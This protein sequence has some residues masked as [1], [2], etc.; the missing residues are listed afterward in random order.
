MKNKINTIIKSTPLLILFCLLISCSQ[1]DY[2]DSDQHETKGNYIE[3]SFN[4]NKNE[5]ITS[6][7]ESTNDIEELYALEFDAKGVFISTQ[8]VDELAES[9]FK[10]MLKPTSEQRIIHFVGGH[11]SVLSS[12]DLLNEVKLKG[13]DE[14]EILPKFTTQ[15]L[16]Y[17]DR[18][19]LKNGIAN[20]TP[21]HTVSL[22]RNKAKL[23]VENQTSTDLFKLHSFAVHKAADSGTI[24]SF[25]SNTDVFDTSNATEP[26]T[27]KYLD[28]TDESFVASQE[29]LSLFERRAAF[30]GSDGSGDLYIILKGEYENEISYYKLPF[31]DHTTLELLPILR[32]H[33]YVLQVMKVGVKG[34]PTLTE[35]LDNPPISNALLDVELQ[36]YSKIAD[37]YNTLEV[38]QIAYF[39]TE[40]G[41]EFELNYTYKH[42]QGNAS[43]GEGEIKLI[44][45]DKLKVFEDFTVM[46]DN[47]EDKGVYSGTVKGRIVSKTPPYGQINTAIVKVQFGHLV[48]NVKVRLG[49]KRKLSA[50]LLTF[51]NKQGKAVDILFDIPEDAIPDKA[52]YPID[53]RINTTLLYPNVD[54]GHNSNLVLKTDGKGGYHYI[55]KAFEPGPQ[56]VHLRRN[57]SNDE[58]LVTLESYYFKWDAIPLKLG[59]IE[60]YTIH[61]LLPESEGESIFDKVF[62]IDNSVYSTVDLE[63]NK[64][65]KR[66]TAGVAKDLPYDKEVV[67]YF[68]IDGQ[69]YFGKSRVDKIR[70]NNQNVRLV[71]STESFEFDIL[72]DGNYPLVGYEY[73]QFSTSSEGVIITYDRHK[74]KFIATI[75]KDLDTSE[76]IEVLVNILDAGIS[77]SGSTTVGE[78]RS[79]NSLSIFE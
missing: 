55:Y 47:Q 53:V 6:R 7:T 10:V 70:E 20:N 68:H 44:E 65:E 35:A 21:I 69:K 17:W 71:L 33:H 73:Y 28:V 48:R 77:A 54:E 31:M 12:F 3:L 26:A 56:V 67:F 8:R 4:F 37:G 2:I 61:F 32:N 14:G 38:S 49:H 5:F 52:I 62:T 66:F 41:E 24:V 18:V 13:K 25:N 57:L 16:V 78:L 64:D 59:V 23:T 76:Q 40:G 9:S 74:E 72:L 19:E 63:V 51:G 45:D 58:E 43:A 60:N 27:A 15:D 50:S 75:D 11:Q 42:K 36:E 1:S 30:K 22:I 46:K 79:G 39:F 29:S 34:Y